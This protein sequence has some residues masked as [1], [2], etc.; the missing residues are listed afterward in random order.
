MTLIEKSRNY[1]YEKIV[2]QETIKAFYNK[3]YETFNEKPYLYDICKDLIYFGSNDYRDFEIYK[4]N[5]WYNDIYDNYKKIQIKS[6][7]YNNA[8]IRFC[9]DYRVKIDSQIYS[10]N[11]SVCLQ[12]DHG[13]PIF[14][15]FNI[16]GIDA[17]ILA[18]EHKYQ[19]L[20]Y[21]FSNY[22]FD[23]KDEATIYGFINDNNLD[24]EITPRDFANGIRR[25]IIS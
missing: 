9:Y 17:P 4:L 3:L 10:L 6:K 16:N 5:E 8:Y 12:F 23:E 1:T 18:S 2:K 20:N 15:A 21:E 11:V 7:I 14:S 19:S 24:V 22:V 25:A 13:K